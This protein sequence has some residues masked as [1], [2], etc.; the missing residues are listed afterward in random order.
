[1][2]ALVAAEHSILVSAWHMLIHGLDCQELGGDYV[3]RLAPDQAARTA[4]RRLGKLGYHITLN[5]MAA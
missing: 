1:M 4:V 5:P 2:R 3:L